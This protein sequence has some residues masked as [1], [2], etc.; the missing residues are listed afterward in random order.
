M[1]LIRTALTLVATVLM[2]LSALAESAG[3]R[4]GTHEGADFVIS[5]PAKWT[6][7]LVMFAHGYQGEGPAAG[8]VEVS[9]LAGHLTARGI[10][11]A[12]SGFR[13]TTY[14]PDWFLDDTLALRARVIREFGPV[15][16]T[17]LHGKS[18]GGHI[19]VAGLELHPEIFQGGLTECGV[20]DGVGLIDWL[21]AYTAAAE[22]FSDAPLLDTPRPAF[23][24]L[25]NEK[26]LPALGMP[27]SYTERGKRFD[28]V[29]KHLSGGD[30]AMRLEGLARRYVLNLNPRLPGPQSAAEFARHGDT[31]HIRY[32]IDPGLGVD[33]DTLNREIRRIEPGPGAR[34]R[35]VNPVFAEL[36]GRLQAP[37][38]TLHETADFRVPLAIEQNY[39]RR[40]DAAGSGKR[41]VQR[42]VA[43]AGH[44][45][46]DGRLREQ[47]FDDLLA[48]METGVAPRGDDLTGDLSKLAR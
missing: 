27:G 16:W 48:W 44:C 31:R 14:R 24:T 28:S 19:A 35:S 26:V 40:V 3:Q 33:A 13:A 5:M 23:N 22:Y 36:T 25:V 45:A 43:G 46:I 6:G 15:R 2:A 30:V 12:A 9:P 4:E 41:L 29:V 20:V 18:M 42:A 39:R 38:L 37:L 7:G 8:S 32:A 11:W 34:S 17:V 47:A 10:A 21:Y 1:T